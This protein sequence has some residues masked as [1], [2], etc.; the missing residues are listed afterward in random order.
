M[1]GPDACVST[2]EGLMTANRTR[3]SANATTRTAALG[4]ARAAAV[5]DQQPNPEAAVDLAEV[6][7]AGLRASRTTPPAAGPDSRARAGG[8]VGRSGQGD[9]SVRRYAFRRS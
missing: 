5:S 2:Q 6:I 9:R 3:R 1:A 4:A 8:K 7:R